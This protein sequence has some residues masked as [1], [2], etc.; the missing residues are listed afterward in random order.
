MKPCGL[1]FGFVVCDIV[2]VLKIPVLRYVDDYLGLDRK[3]CIIHGMDCFVRIVRC[4]LGTSAMSEEKIGA[5]ITMEFLGICVN[6]TIEG[7]S[8]WPSRAKVLRWLAD[9]EHALVH[10]RLSAGDASKLVGRLAFANQVIFK[11]LGRA[12]LRPLY[13][14][15]NAPMHNGR[16]SNLLRLSLQWWKSV[17]SLEIRDTVSLK[18]KLCDVVELFGDARGSP[19]RVAS[20]LLKDGRV[21][22]SS[23]QPDEEVMMTFCARNDQQIMGQELLAV[24]FGM[25][26]FLEQIRG[27]CVRIWIDNA[28]GE[29][30]LERGA[31]SSFDHNALVHG[32]W[33]LAARHGFGLWI[34]RVASEW[35]IA[36]EPS[37]EVYDG[38]ESIGA[39]WVEPI[40]RDEFWNPCEWLEQLPD[41]R[42]VD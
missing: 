1:R 42:G 5:G 21:Q 9:I 12:M 6:P 11:R 38:L 18:P 16:L 36:D 4:I 37:R 14:Q 24:L 13:A 32:M 19:P 10:D 7:I 31:A 25:S 20:V 41:A 26:T 27:T 3:D 17:L 33:L 40:L 2:Q 8:F 34:E 35:N 15:Q 29:A 39:A 28:A 30:V 22:Y 23:W